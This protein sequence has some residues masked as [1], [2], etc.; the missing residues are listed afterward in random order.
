VSATPIQL[1]SEVE[2]L[3]AAAHLPTSDLRETDRLKMF[4]VRTHEC[5]VGV[6][7]I[8]HYGRVGLLRSLAVIEAQRNHRHGRVLVSYAES[9]ASQQ[10]VE[11]LYLLTTTAAGFF[12]RLGYEETPRSEA[13]AVISGTSQFAGLCPSSSIFMS[14]VLASNNSYMDSSHK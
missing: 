10:G 9:W 5:L 4:G 11:M 7:G 12:A 1:N 14:K 2:L 3:L 13:P 8:E 6:V